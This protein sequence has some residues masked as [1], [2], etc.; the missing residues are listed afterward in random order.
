MTNCGRLQVGFL[1]GG[2]VITERLFARRGLGRIAVQAVIDQDLPVVQGVV[3][4]AAI[5]YT[6]ANLLADLA[7]L[8]LD[9][10]LRK[11]AK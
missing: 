6:L 10:R 2:T 9:P 4:L 11:S 5:T 3:L 7:H 1:L 8:W